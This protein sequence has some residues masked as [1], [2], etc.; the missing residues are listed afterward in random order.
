MNISRDN[1]GSCLGLELFPKYLGNKCLSPFLSLAVSK[2][3]TVFQK[4]REGLVISFS[5]F[6]AVFIGSYLR[7]YCDRF[8]GRSIF[9]DSGKISRWQYVG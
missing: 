6:S 7:I 9:L 3:I 5:P 8:H 2:L 1:G 4:H